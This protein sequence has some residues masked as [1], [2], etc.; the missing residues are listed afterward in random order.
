MKIN[1]QGAE[2]D[3]SVEEGKEVIN[4]LFLRNHTLPA[5]IKYLQNKKFKRTNYVKKGNRTCRICGD[6]L[7]FHKISLCGKPECKKEAGRQRCLKYVLKR[8]RNGGKPLGNTSATKR[9]TVPVS[10][11]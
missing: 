10:F 6:V 9:I 1:I 5:S 3:C 4:Y 11:V 8:Q 2:I 7:P